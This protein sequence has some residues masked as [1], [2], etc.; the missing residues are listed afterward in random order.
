MRKTGG[1]DGA[2]HAS[3]YP[4]QLIGARSKPEIGPHFTLHPGR[5]TELEPSASYWMNTIVI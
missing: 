4:L 3:A 5:L 2:Q 1:G